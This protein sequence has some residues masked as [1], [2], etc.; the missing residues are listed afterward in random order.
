[1]VVIDAGAIGMTTAMELARAG[2]RVTVLERGFGPGAGCSAGSAGLINV[3]HAA[4]VAT[5]ESL[6]AG[7]AWM[8]RRESPFALRP[9]ARLTPWLV[10]FARAALTAEGVGA[11]TRLLR[12]LAR[13]GHALHG[14]LARQ[15]VAVGYERR[16]IVYAFDGAAAVAGPLRAELL[17][18]GR[19]G[20]ACG[21]VPDAP[22][23]ICSRSRSGSDSYANQRRERSAG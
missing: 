10:R 23:V 14:E 5:P 19:P 3:S 4:P 18:G 13:A 15:G 8:L 21:Q 16:G 6:R 7:L 17:P 1:V 2:A 9:R 12:A 22:S 11:A 20:A